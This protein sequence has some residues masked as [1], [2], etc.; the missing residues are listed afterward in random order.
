MNQSERLSTMTTHTRFVSSVFV[1]A[2]TIGL[3]VSPAC[4]VA[5]ELAPLAALVVSPDGSQVIAG[6][7]LGIEVRRWHDL[8]PDRRLTTRMLHVHDLA[9]SKQRSLACGGRRCSQPRWDGRRLQLARRRVTS[10]D[11]LPLGSDL[12][13][14]VEPRRLDV[15]NRRLRQYVS[16]AACGH[17]RK[18][19]NHPRSLAVAQV[20]PLS[21]RGRVHHHHRH[22]PDRTSLGNRVG[23]TRSNTEQSY[24]FGSRHRCLPARD[25]RAAAIDRHG[26]RRSHRQILAADHRSVWSDLPD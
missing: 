12:R 10:R 15:G 18:N 6:S 8:E 26:Q 22:R 17:W 23:Q 7:Q 9:F 25:L 13:L 2:L 5:N 11:K 14:G 16:S 21:R 19:S 1:V 4:S 3:V 24:S 20:G